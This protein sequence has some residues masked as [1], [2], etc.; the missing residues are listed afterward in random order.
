MKESLNQVISTLALLDIGGGALVP[1]VQYV[2]DA[3]AKDS[4]FRATRRP[5]QYTMEKWL[6]NLTDKAGLR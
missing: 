4:A 2:V 1:G 5:S 6:V 3:V